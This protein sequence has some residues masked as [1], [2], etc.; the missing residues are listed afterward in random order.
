MLSCI[1]LPDSVGIGSSGAVLGML[2]AWIVWILFRWGKVPAESRGLRNCQLIVVTAAVVLTLAFSFTDFGAWMLCLPTKSLCV[3]VC[4]LHIPC[5]PILLA[6]TLTLAL[7]PPSVDWAA[8]FGGSV[9]GGIA[10]AMMLS[11]E[12]EHF[13][14]RWGVRTLAALAFVVSY[15][16]ALVGHVGQEEEEEEGED[17]FYDIMSNICIILFD[18]VCHNNEWCVC[19]LD[20]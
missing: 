11:R 8:H 13:Y 20:G 10:A 14:L 7:S 9:Q 4:L 5:S 3:C 19:L 17:D 16:W 2:T 6:L 18:Y 15:T 12:V 1:F